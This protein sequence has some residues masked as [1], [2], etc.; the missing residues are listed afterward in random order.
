M[1]YEFRIKAINAEKV[2]KLQIF[3]ENINKDT[4]EEI[5]EDSMIDEFHC[6]KQENSDCIDN[7]DEIFDNSKVTTHPIKVECILPDEESQDMNIS[8]PYIVLN[9]SMFKLKEPVNEN[10]DNQKSSISL[11][12]PYSFNESLIENEIVY[13]NHQTK[14][15]KRRSKRS[16]ICCVESCRT[17]KHDNYRLF[18]VTQHR[19]NVIDWLEKLK[20]T[21]DDIKKPKLLVCERHFEKKYV[22]GYKLVP[23]AIPTLFLEQTNIES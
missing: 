9:S 7:K 8:N 2:L 4:F 11:V 14:K 6:I 23:T 19:F 10:E 16:S 12:S 15:S 17:N 20:L 18:A 3:E 22:G 21:S 1:A 5:R 13:S